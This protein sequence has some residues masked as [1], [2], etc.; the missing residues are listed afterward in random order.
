MNEGYVPIEQLAKYLSVKIPTIRDWVLKGY[1]PK[2]TYIKVASTY[3]FSIPHVIAALRQE[4]TEPTQ[5]NQN[6]PVQLEL[7]FSDEEDV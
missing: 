1:I 6:E 4:A 3:R 5:D 7:D 2:T